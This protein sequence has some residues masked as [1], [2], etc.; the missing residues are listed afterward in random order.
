MSFDLSV[1]RRGAEDAVGEAAESGIGLFVGAVTP[2]QAKAPAPGR[3]A[4]ERETATAVIALWRRIGLPAGR[5]TEQV[6]VTPACGLAGAS[7]ASA[8]A[9]LTRCQAAARLI[10]ELI[11]EGAA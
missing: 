1:L 5:L 2:V 6:V 3:T 9:V 10:P 4:P 7:P 8:R 11:E